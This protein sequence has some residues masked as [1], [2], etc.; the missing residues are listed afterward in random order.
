MKNSTAPTKVA[1]LTRETSS[2]SRGDGRKTAPSAETPNAME[3]KRLT[4]AIHQSRAL[5]APL[6]R[7][8]QEAITLDR[9]NAIEPN[10]SGAHTSRFI[11]STERFFARAANVLVLR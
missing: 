1:M 2:I 6:T 10:T 11:C 8:A 4:A 5:A 3:P 7:T 9:R